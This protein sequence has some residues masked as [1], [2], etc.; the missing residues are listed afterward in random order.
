[1][2]SEIVDGPVRLLCEYA[3]DMFMFCTYRG[4]LWRDFFVE[5]DYLFSSAKM[6]CYPLQVN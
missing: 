6:L 4:A 2:K 1:M 3:I 5:L